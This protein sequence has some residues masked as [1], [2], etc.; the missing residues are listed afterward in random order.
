MIHYQF[1]ESPLGQL[2]LTS[3]GRSALPS[4]RESLTGLY[5][6]NQKHYPEITED[7]RESPNLEIFRQAQEQLIAYF[8]HQ[9]QSFDLPLAPR[10]TEFQQQVWQQLRQI[11]YGTAISYGTL[12]QQIGQ[13]KAARAV[14]MANGRNPLSI[15]VPCHRVI[16]SNGKLTGYAGGIDRKQWL[17]QHE[18][19]VRKSPTRSF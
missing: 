19:Q 8:A 9:R 4:P 16:A 12:A 1:I 10:G 18:Q 15:I 7:W 14:G 6:Q 3:D 2:L 11:S 5:L 13:P 17:L